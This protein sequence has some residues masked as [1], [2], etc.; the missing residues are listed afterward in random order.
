MM[1]KQLLKLVGYAVLA[2]LTLEVAARLD[3]AVNEGA[4]FFKPYSINTLFRP[5][6][7]GREGKPDSR[8]GKWSMNSLGYRGP[9]PAAQRI[10]VLTFGASETFGLYES[11]DHEYPRRLESALNA[12]GSARFNVINLA[13]PGVRIGRWGYLV[14]GIRKTQAQAVV[15][16]PSPANYIGTT[17]ALCD[18]PTRPVPDDVGVLDQLR[19]RGKVETLAKA[20]TPPWMLTLFREYSVWRQAS[21]VETLERVHEATID[22]FKTDMRCAARA[23]QRAGAKV[24]FATHATYFGGTLRPADRP[25]MIAWRRFYPELGESGFLDLESRA[26]AALKLVGE[27]LNI[28]VVDASAAIPPGPVYFADFVHFTDSG[29]LQMAALLTPAVLSVLRP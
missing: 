24:V 26:N 22:A 10:N 20:T 21:G 29:A 3:D 25:M 6:P 12:S 23:A 17:E 11:A 1:L 2:T 14:E 27:E 9:E 5:S 8:F 16:Y 28:P 18:K 7:F 15:I 19:I 13:L 4:P